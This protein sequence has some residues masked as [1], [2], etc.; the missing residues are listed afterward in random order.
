MSTP[1]P[2]PRTHLT[3]AGL[4]LS[5]L[6]PPSAPKEALSPFLT[7]LL[8]EAIPLLDSL[9]PPST[10]T[11]TPTPADP[12]PSTYKWTT[13]PP[14]SYRPTSDA[15]VQ[16]YRLTTTPPSNPDDKT[17]GN[18]RNKETWT[19]R[20]STHHPAA[21]RRGTASFSEFQTYL[22]DRHVDTEAASTKSVEGVWRGPAWG[23][24]DGL[25]VEAAGHRWSQF[26]M[27]ALATR[28]RIGRPVLRDRAFPLV[29]VTCSSASGEGEFLVITLYVPDLLTS[30][31]AAFPDDNDG[32]SRSPSPGSR[33]IKDKSKQDVARDAVAAAYVSVERVRRLPGDGDGDG[34]V[35]WIMATAS[36]AKGVLP[37]FVQTRAVPGQVA[38]DVPYFL[39]WVD[40]ER[41][42]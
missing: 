33:R 27:Q 18:E 6:P 29:Q 31:S 4:S 23:A 39:G 28:H 14:K 42:K 24:C 32:P 36:D 9:P 16:L 2:P 38:V 17:L 35:E 41:G 25:Q 1:H 3:L 5:Q 15:E 40:G 34:S 30:S 26:T 12:T 22:K 7:T 19:A 8:E 21:P 10:T 13:H 20:R 37:M 11:N